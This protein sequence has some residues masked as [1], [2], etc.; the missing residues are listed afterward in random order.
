MNPKKT[1]Y[2]NRLSNFFIQSLLPNL[3]TNQFLLINR[4]VLLA[5]VFMTCMA[6]LSVFAQCPSSLT[7]PDVTTCVGE[8][9][10]LSVTEYIGMCNPSTGQWEVSTDGGNNWQNCT[11]GAVY[12]NVAGLPMTII[13]AG[14]SLNGSKYRYNWTY[15]GYTITSSVSTLTVNEI[16]LITAQPVDI[17]VCEGIQTSTSIG[18]TGTPGLI[19]WQFLDE[20]TWTDITAVHILYEDYNNDTLTIPSPASGMN[21]TQLRCKLIYCGNE[22]ISDTITV[23]VSEAPDNPGPITGEAS[24]CQGDSKIYSISPVSGANGYEWTV[25]AG[26]TPSGGTTN[27]VS[28]YFSENAAHSSSISVK[29][30]AN[31]GCKSP[32]S[33]SFELTVESSPKLSISVSME[34]PS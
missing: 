19:Q 27:E 7:A 4:R 34:N 17:S 29:A 3:K 26:V 28:L 31:S 9:P 33:S 23:N 5:I 25:P 12:S 14:L 1:T 22:I 20:G 2:K 30:T 18:F 32:N 8:S 21:G 11:E 16:P 24:V 6:S 13:H 15:D 10:N